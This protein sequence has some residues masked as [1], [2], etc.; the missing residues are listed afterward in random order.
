MQEYDK[1][2]KW[3]IEN[4]GDSILRLGGARGIVW[5]KALQT[6][7]VQTRRLPDGLLEAKLRGRARP[8][9]FLV[10]VSTYPY[11]RL[12]KQAVDGSMLVFLARGELPE[13]LTL[14][15]HP[16]D[17]ARPTGTVELSSPQG[18]TR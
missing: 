9:R 1:S 17:R 3:L 10:E 16:G 14:I 8:V 5:W 6:D 4:H 12:S 2:S 18:W 13:V 15:L 11:R 7:L